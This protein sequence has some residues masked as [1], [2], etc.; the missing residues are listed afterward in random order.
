MD[1]FDLNSI[2]QHDQIA[3]EMT[4]RAAVIA[5]FYRALVEGGMPEELAGTIV[6]D[7][8]HTSFQVEA[9][10]RCDCDCDVCQG[11]AQG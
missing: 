1:T 8:A 4:R 2:S 11:E 7:W 3:T 5:Q 6:A 10:P 9:D